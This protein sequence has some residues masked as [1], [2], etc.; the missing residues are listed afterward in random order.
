[1]LMVDDGLYAAEGTRERVELTGE[2]EHHRDV[3]AVRVAVGR[4]AAPRRKGTPGT[5]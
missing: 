4:V 2:L 1:M 3:V 5:Q